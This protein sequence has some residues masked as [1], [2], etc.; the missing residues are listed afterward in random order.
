LLV[1]AKQVGDLHE[2]FRRLLTRPEITGL[3]KVRL[4]M[5]EAIEIARQ[6]GGV[7]SWAHPPADATRE[8]AATLKLW[9]LGAIE[10]Q[11][12]W[13]KPSHGRRLRALAESV[14]LA[15]TG[16]SD[17]HG[18]TPRQRAIGAKG[19]TVAELDAL[20]GRSNARR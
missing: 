16:G 15:I 4:P 14:G 13:A 8:Q 6:A 10:C 20:R 18:P 7:A 9:G 11:Y 3:P 12:P 19:I 17:C 5:P 1:D 2:A